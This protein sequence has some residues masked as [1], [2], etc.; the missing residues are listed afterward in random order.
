MWDWHCTLPPEA[1]TLNPQSPCQ[2]P[3]APEP[4]LGAG[5]TKGVEAMF[6]MHVWPTLPTGLLASREGA[7]MAAS[8]IFEVTVKGRGGHAAMPHL[9]RDPIVAMA[10]AISAVQVDEVAG[11]CSGCAFGLRAWGPCCL[12]AAALWS[13]V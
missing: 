1:W 7:L 4:C 11:Q 2:S 6:G 9:T 10:Q 3:Q 8:L 13:R 12:V 5:A